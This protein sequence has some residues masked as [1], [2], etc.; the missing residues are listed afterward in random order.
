MIRS[1]DEA[2]CA[3]ADWM[4]LPEQ[5]ERLVRATVEVMGCADPEARAFLTD[6]M[7]LLVK[8]GLEG[9]R[10]HQAE[11]STIIV[12]DPDEDALFGDLTE[13]HLALRFADVV[14]Q[15]F[16]ALAVEYARWE[17]ARAI[18]FHEGAIREA[19]AEGFRLRRDGE[20][21]EECR[22]AVEALVLASQPEWRFREADLRDACAVTHTDDD[23]LFEAVACS[24]TVTIELLDAIDVNPGHAEGLLHRV[25]L[26]RDE[27][28]EAVRTDPRQV[29]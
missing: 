11:D 17:I 10:R 14:V 15:V 21:V 24:D 29:A 6:C 4:D 18:R 5:R 1:R 13:A 7:A 19:V 20:S 16:P 3:V 27:I 12:L 9:F 26:F 2:F 28:A 25:R 22:V 23:S 8:N